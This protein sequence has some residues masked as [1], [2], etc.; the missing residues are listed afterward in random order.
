MSSPEEKLARWA[1]RDA[2]VGLTAELAQVRLDLAARDAEIADLRA[3]N[4]QLAQ[5]GAQLRV[6]RDHVTRLNR[7]LQKPSISRRV[8]H[9][10]RWIAG[11]LAR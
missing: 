9:R 7:R 11:K 3:R 4:E 10:L 1:E 5:R 2:V 8:V 6:E